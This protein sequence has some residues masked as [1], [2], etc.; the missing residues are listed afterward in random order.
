MPVPFSAPERFFASDNNAAV[1]PAVLE[2]IAAVNHGH[3]VAYGDDPVTRRAEALFD[4]IFG[5]AVDT[6]F[7]WNGTGANVLALATCLRPA[8][9]VVCT[10]CAHINVDETGAPERF[11]GSKLI[12]V[13][14][15]AGKLSPD[16]VRSLSHDLGVVHHVQPAVVSI[17]QSTEWGSVYT[18]DEIGELCDVAHGMG[19]LVHLDGARMANAVARLGG[20]IDTLR[21]MTIGAGVDVVSFGG[22]KNGLMYGEAVVYLDREAAKFAPFVRKQVTQ[23]PSKV[24]YISAQF[25]A[26]FTD[27]LWLDN[28]GRANAAALDLYETVRDVPGILV[29]KPEVNSLYPVVPAHI[30]EPLRAWSFFYDWNPQRDQVRWMTAWDTTA[31]DIATFV[32]GLRHVAS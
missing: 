26:F 3:A 5:R 25:L 32:R 12:D 19:M 15:V 21:A 1:H 30:R 24:R 22:T 29:D 23:L 28:A 7:V 4:E 16:A 17:T 13:P 10:D 11:L 6:F 20:G 31:A 2:A 14:H 8:G 27:D 9:A 18:V